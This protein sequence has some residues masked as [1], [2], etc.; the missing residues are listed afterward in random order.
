MLAETLNNELD[1]SDVP[2]SLAGVLRL[3]HHFGEVRVVDGC[4]EFFEGS[5]GEGFFVPGVVEFLIVDDAGVL[6]LGEFLCWFRLGA[7]LFDVA[8]LLRNQRNGL[9]V[10]E[11]L[12]CNLKDIPLTNVK[13]ESH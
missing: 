11:I 13:V 6:D 9:A 8:I 4:G 5:A 2:G 1:G 12:M 3:L 7:I 10:D